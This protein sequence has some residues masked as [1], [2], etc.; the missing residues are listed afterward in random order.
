MQ[1]HH[2]DHNRQHNCPCNL[3]LID[4]AINRAITADRRRWLRAFHRAEVLRKLREAAAHESE[5]S[6]G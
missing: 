5:V 3:M 2:I 4:A 1:V 6:S